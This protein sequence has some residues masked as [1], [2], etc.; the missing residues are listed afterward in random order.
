MS[1]KFWQSDEEELR[2]RVADFPN[3]F[4]RLRLNWIRFKMGLEKGLFGTE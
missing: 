3:Q 2:D 1:W 4:E